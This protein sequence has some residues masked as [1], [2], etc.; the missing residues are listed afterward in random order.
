MKMKQI[1]MV[2]VFASLAVAQY[3][4][5]F[6]Y[7]GDRVVA[8][9]TLSTLAPAVLGASPGPG[10]GY[11]ET[12]TF[13]FAHG[14]GASTLTTLYV[15]I[16][17]D[18]SAYHACHFGVNVASGVLSL[19]NDTGSSY[20]DLALFGPTPS[21]TTVSNSQCTISRTTANQS[22]LVLDA[23]GAT[24]KVHI[25]FSPSFAF[26][27][28]P[29]PTPATPAGRKVIYTAALSSGGGSTG[30]QAY[31]SWQVP[32]APTTV[33]RVD[34]MT[35]PRGE[36]QRQRYT[37]VFSSTNGYGNL[38]VQNILVQSALDGTN[39]CF[40]A[41]AAPSNELFLV[42]NDGSGL[43]ALAPAGSATS[44][45]FT[46]TMANSQCRIHGAT[47]SYSKAGNTV[48][49]TVDIEYL[50]AFIGNKILF[51]ASRITGDISSGWQ[52]MGTWSLD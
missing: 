23:N 22:S 45:S 9:E 33:P 18:L 25:T 15:L 31:G 44:G 39:A 8:T 38:T 49:L 52:N 3:K 46:G 32:W 27:T 41:Y 17:T 26:K 48:T 12:F 51:A 14:A 21:P 43:F 1:V 19:V 13:G 29:P 2:V 16:N 5:E 11:S 36:A 40:L 35:P 42:T 30:W 50:P 24:L 37:A 20:S 4:R 28:S 7:A 47:S 10:T 34:S 6:L